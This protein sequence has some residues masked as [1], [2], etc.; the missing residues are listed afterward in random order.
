MTRHLT[1]IPL[2]ATLLALPLPGHASVGDEYGRSLALY[3]AAHYAEARA[4]FDRLLQRFPAGDHTD[5][6]LYW[7]GETFYAEG[8]YEQALERFREVV[9]R[10]PDQPKAPDALF[11][12]ALCNDKLSRVHGYRNSLYGLVARYPK[13]DAAGRAARLLEKMEVAP[14]ATPRP[15]AEPADTSRIAVAPAAPEAL[16]PL[17]SAAPDL[18]GLLL[19]EN[20]MAAALPT[21][22]SAESL[23]ELRLRLE[24]ERKELERAANDE[25][26]VGEILLSVVAPGGF[27]Y[28]AHRETERLRAEEELKLIDQD[29]ALVEAET[30]RLA[31]ET[32]ASAPVIAKAP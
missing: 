16:P 6:A 5:N 23:R 12:I 24:E 9:T 7:I 31:E 8:R 21:A 27:L 4:A 13:A 11:K 18:D 3:R 26:S 20:G 22:P 19:D 10:L 15:P 25:L 14:A 28:M 29:F 2:L 17:P 32:P 30:R 1:L